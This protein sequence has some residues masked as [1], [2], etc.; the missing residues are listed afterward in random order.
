MRE[1]PKRLQEDQLNKVQIVGCFF[2]GGGYLLMGVAFGGPPFL[3]R[4]LGSVA[5]ALP[6][7]GIGSMLVGVGL[8]LYGAKIRKR[9]PK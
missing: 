9:R 5:N 3:M 2:C 4:A 8:V 7:L 6:F 1:N